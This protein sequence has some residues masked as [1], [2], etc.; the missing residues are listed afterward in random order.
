MTEYSSNLSDKKWSII[1]PI[2]EE[3]YPPY[4]LERP[5]GGRVMWVD[6][7]EILNGIFY[8]SKTG[9]QW[10]MIPKDLPAKGTVYDH[11]RKLK[12][13]GAWGKILEKTNR[14]VREEEGRKEHPT[15]G[16]VDSQSTKTIYKGE[17]RGIDGNK[18]IKGRKRHIV[19]DVLRCLL[20]IIVH[21]ANIH[22]TKAANGVMIQAIQKYPSLK[23]FCGDEGYRGTAVDDAALLERPMEISKR[24]IGEKSDTK[25]WQ[26]IPKRWIVERTFAWWQNFRRLSKDYEVNPSNSETIAKVVAIRLN[27]KKLSIKNS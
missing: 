10:E 9:C 27:L 20:A 22:D 17:E 1:E 7:R 11:Y 12:T 26:V 23:A 15:F 6:M 21:V 5:K 14:A 19:V 18:K 4:S 13:S 2:L 16:L 3:N 25:K 8:V 24:I